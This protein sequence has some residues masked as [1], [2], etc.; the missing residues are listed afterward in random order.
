MPT[1]T[2]LIP[3]WLNREWLR[4]Y[5]EYRIGSGTTTRIQI[6][7]DNTTRAAF[8]IPNP[9]TASTYAALE[10]FNSLLSEYPDDP[11]L[12]EKFWEEM[13]TQDERDFLEV[14]NRVLELYAELGSAPREAA[15]GKI[16]RVIIG[17]FEWQTSEMGL[18][19]WADVHRWFSGKEL[20]VKLRKKEEKEK[21]K[22]IYL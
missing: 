15:Y 2:R 8:T 4:Y 14:R 1:S 21:K 5:E 18:T 7:T 9:P 22:A 6:D 12:H 17:A 10:W 11:Y 16:A 13:H 20:E 3:D 19:Y